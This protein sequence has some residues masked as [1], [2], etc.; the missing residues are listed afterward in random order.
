M[1]DVSMGRGSPGFADHGCRSV[2]RIRAVARLAV[3]VAPLRAG[4]ARG[5]SHEPEPQ[6]YTG[7][8]KD[9]TDIFSLPACTI[10]R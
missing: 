7:S 2:D 3:A 8:V 10:V 4:D 5:A 9:I 6:R 1:E